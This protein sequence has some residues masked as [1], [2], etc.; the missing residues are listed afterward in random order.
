MAIRCQGAMWKRS[1]AIDRRTAHCGVDLG[2]IRSLARGPALAAGATTS[3]AVL[4]TTVVVTN[5]GP[6]AKGAHQSR[7]LLSYFP[8][9]A[10][11]APQGPRRPP[12][13][14]PRYRRR[15]ESPGSTGQGCRRTTCRGDSKESA[16]ENRP[17]HRAF[18]L[19]GQG[20]TV[21]QERTAPAE[22]SVAGQT[23]P[24]AR[25]EVSR[26]LRSTASAARATSKSR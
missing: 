18:G 25:R 6:K 7:S 1:S 13:E 10:R 8:L 23:P 20:E 11:S 5:A 16:T 12:V 14:M 15:E 9:R 24:G 3:P 2:G 26:R 17:P 21:R 19:W 4:G 22:T